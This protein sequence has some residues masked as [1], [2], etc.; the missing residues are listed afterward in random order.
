VVG[1][2]LLRPVHKGATVSLDDVS[3]A[4]V[5]R[6]GDKVDVDLE[7]SDLHLRFEAAAEKDGRYGDLIPLRNLQSSMIFE[8]EVSG[9]DQ[10]RVVVEK[11]DETNH[12]GADLRATGG[13]C[14]G[15]REK[16]KGCQ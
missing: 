6:R 10:A 11:L 2:N 9:K 7:S 14:G 15:D 5:I 13:P 4:M 1:K 12:S 16:E 8:A 3:T